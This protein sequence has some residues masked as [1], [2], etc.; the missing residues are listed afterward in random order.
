MEFSLKAATLL[1]QP[2]WFGIYVCTLCV[3]TLAGCVPVATFKSP[4]QAH[5][6]N[7]ML[8]PSFLGLFV[9]ST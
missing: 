6:D 9:F 1:L 7:T 2:R 4:M 8:L 3:N 5:K